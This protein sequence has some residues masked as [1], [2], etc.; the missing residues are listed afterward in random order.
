MSTKNNYM[1]H[2]KKICTRK[3]HCNQN[4]TRGPTKYRTGPQKIRGGVSPVLSDYG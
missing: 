2:I 4:N 3:L 1:A